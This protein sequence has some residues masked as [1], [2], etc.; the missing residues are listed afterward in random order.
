MY[1][2][3]GIH[4][5][6]PLSSAF[7]A[8]I[9]EVNGHSKKLKPDGNQLMIIG[10]YI[11]PKGNHLMIILSFKNFEIMLSMLFFRNLEDYNGYMIGHVQLYGYMILYVNGGIFFSNLGSDGNHLIIW[12][13]A[14][15]A[16][17]VAGY[18]W[19]Y[20]TYALYIGDYNNP[21][22]GNPYK[23]TRIMEW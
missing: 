1:S 19:L 8:Q 7:L 13:V 9:W 2:W 15:K 23:P 16:L 10:D 21:R 12:A 6:H 3:N 20:T 17:L 4:S 11:L 22:T 18:R 14:A 5:Y